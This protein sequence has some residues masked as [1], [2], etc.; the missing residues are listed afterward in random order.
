MGKSSCK[1]ERRIEGGHFHQENLPLFSTEAFQIE[2]LDSNNN[3]GSLVEAFMKRKDKNEKQNHSANDALFTS[4]R[5]RFTR[6]NG[7]TFQSDSHSLR[8]G[9][10]E[11]GQ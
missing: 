9:P 7:A 8:G 2:H 3:K 11:S 1:Y 10:Y 6:G 4:N 5:E